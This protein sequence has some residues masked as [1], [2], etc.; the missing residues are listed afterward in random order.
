MVPWATIFHPP[1]PDGH[2]HNTREAGRT[3]ITPFAS[4]GSLFGPP[5]PSPTPLL[6]GCVERESDDVALNF[7]QTIANAGGWP[8]PSCRA[9]V[10]LPMLCQVIVVRIVEVEQLAGS[11]I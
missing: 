9:V 3:L 10:L 11:Q 7:A 5:R 8:S 4:F 6:V 1:A 2:G